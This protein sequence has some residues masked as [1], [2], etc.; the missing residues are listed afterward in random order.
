[1]EQLEDNLYSLTIADMRSYYGIP[2][3]ETIE[4]LAFVFRS[5]VENAEGYFLEQKM[6]TA[7]TFL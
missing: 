7:L 4:K 3:A 6:P 1:M 2:A 5:D